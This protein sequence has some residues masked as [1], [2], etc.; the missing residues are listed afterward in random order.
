MGEKIVWNGREREVVRI[1]SDCKDHAGYYTTF[2]DMMK[3]GD[4]EYLEV[5]ENKPAAG[6]AN[7]EPAKPKKRTK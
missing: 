1:K 3:P 2:R 6:D 7:P 5:G 4:V